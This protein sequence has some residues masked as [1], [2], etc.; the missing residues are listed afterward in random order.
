MSRPRGS[1]RT[2]LVL[3]KWQLLLESNGPVCG[4]ESC[5]SHGHWALQARLE[6]CNDQ[7]GLW[8]PGRGGGRT[9]AGR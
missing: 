4:G 2:W 8:T 6:H 1:T 5:E 7:R 9:R 3:P